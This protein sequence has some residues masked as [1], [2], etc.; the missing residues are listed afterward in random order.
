MSSEHTCI[1]ASTY[2][3][4]GPHG[5]VN[6]TRA[7]SALNDLKSTA[8]AE[9]EVAGWDT[10]V[11]EGEVSMSMGSVV[12]AIYTQHAVDSD[13]LG[14]GR[15]KNHRLLAV[16]VLIL[17]IRLAHDNVNLTP[18]VARATGPPFL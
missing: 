2:G 10:N 13:T 15:Y 6:T 14:V 8:L 4:N 5:V 9:D 1:Y 3:A 7:K 16:D 18:W 11:V 17:R 12:V